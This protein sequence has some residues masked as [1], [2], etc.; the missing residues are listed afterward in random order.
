MPET[1]TTFLER[2]VN[3]KSTAEFIRTR[4]IYKSLDAALTATLRPQ[5]VRQKY[6]KMLISRRASN[7]ERVA[8]GTNLIDTFV[9]GFAHKL[10]T[11]LINSSR[12]PFA[13]ADL[14]LMS[15]GSGSTV[16]LLKRPEEDWVLK[17]YRRSL[18][19]KGESLAQIAAH[20]KVKYETVCSWYNSRF[21]L[22]PEAHFLIL[23]GPIFS[24]PA[25]AVLQRYIHGNK[26]DFFLDH[27]NQTLLH[28][29]NQDP[30]LV[31]SFLF[32][33]EQTFKIQQQHNLCVD[34]L[35]RENL[36]LVEQNGRYKLLVVDNGIFNLATVQHNAPEIWNR[37]E[38]R[39]ERIRNLHRLLA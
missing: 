12:F 28:L 3:W 10:S 36:M 22:V 23:Y 9:P 32:F 2:W 15:Y 37:I 33:A 20:F 26:S 11:R 29:M 27:S 4:L 8:A 18:G 24:K 6:L 25:A 31:G 34:F 7:Y 1:P 16:F 21:N 14:Q 17:I 39:L 30:E 5:Q 13:N 38:I 35:G 19:K